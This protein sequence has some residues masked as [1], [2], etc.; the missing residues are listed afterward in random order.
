MQ[1]AR[2]SVFLFS[3]T[4]AVAL[5]NVASATERADIVAGLNALPLLTSKLTGDITMAVIYDPADA[6]S[7]AEATGI[8]AIVDAGMPVPGG[9]KLSAI[10]VG[11]G[12]LS[13]LA[14]AQI[15]FVTKGLTQYYADISTATSAASILT[16]TT[17]IDCVSAAKCI[18]GVA[19]KPGIT[20]Y[21]SKTA[22]DS[23]KI[24]FMQEF[25][26]LAKQL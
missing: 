19:T 3:L 1:I 20:I 10:L 4:F 9:G 21:F 5:P 17:D 6:V 2:L 12:E 15:A 13:K 11:V 16:I 7:S 22:S 14:R 24:E 26:M 18:L 8:K 23:A 25:I